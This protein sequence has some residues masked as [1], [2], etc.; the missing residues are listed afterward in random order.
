MRKATKAPN[1]LNHHLIIGYRYH[2]RCLDG[3]LFTEILS[4]VTVKVS[5]FLRHYGWV[6]LA[7]GITTLIH[8]CIRQRKDN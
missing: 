3:A 1:K 6:M 4:F 7:W 2:N 5:P 8:V